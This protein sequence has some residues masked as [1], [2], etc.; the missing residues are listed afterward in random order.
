MKK[1][2]VFLLVNCFYVFHA[3]TL[4]KKDVDFMNKAAGGGLMEVR[5]GELSQMNAATPEVKNAGR[6]M[7]TDHSKAGEELKSL[8]LS[9]NVLLPESM[10]PKEQKKYDE[11]A[12]LTGKKFDK[13]YAKC[14]VKDHKKDIAEFKKEAKSGDDPAVKSWAEGKVATLEAHLQLWKDACKAAEK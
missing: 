14:M 7:V 10:D 5:L 1:I 9:K 6:T 3:Q 2:I 12:K 4:S 13:A 11:L 8:A